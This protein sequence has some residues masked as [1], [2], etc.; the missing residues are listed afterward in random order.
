[1]DTQASWYA[2][3]GA[4]ELPPNL[5]CI[6][7]S[8]PHHNYTSPIPATEK[9]GCSADTRIIDATNKH[10]QY[11]LLTRQISNSNP[12]GRTGLSLC[13]LKQIHLH[14]R[15][16]SETVIEQYLCSAGLWSVSILPLLEEV[17]KAC[18][19]SLATLP[20][21]HA[22]VSTDPPLSQKHQR[23]QI[24]VVFF[25]SASFLRVIDH[26]SPRSKFG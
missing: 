18:L 7:Y 1:M 6:H 2:T 20:T 11:C 16:G 13:N 25:S 8:Q 23:S 26:A 24:D 15:H 4:S 9:E 3:P 14:L 21:P 22:V 19:W 5:V 17:V 12:I 10:K